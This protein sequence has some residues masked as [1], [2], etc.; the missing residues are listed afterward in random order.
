[1][2]FRMIPRM[3]PRMSPRLIRLFLAPLSALL[4]LCAA[5]ST[6]AQ[7]CLTT[8]SC[9]AVHSPG[10]CNSAACCL[11]VCTVDPTCCSGNWDA[12][13]VTT[14]NQ[15]CVGYCGAAISGSC[16]SSH[17][18]PACSNATCCN[19]VCATDPYCCATAWDV[20]CAQYASFLCPGTPGT[21][22]SAS[23]SCFAVHSTGACSDATCCNA[24][25]TIDPTCCSSAWVM[26]CVYAANETC[27]AGC[28]PVIESNAQVEVEE[29][30]FS[31]NDPCFTQ[32][33]GAPEEITLGRQ[34]FGRLGRAATFV[35]P[36]D[37][38]V[39][40]FSVTDTDGDGGA[41]VT[42]TF[43]SS[44]VAWAAIVSDAACAPL[45]SALRTVSSQLCVDTVSASVCLAPGNYRVVVAAGAYPT[46]GGADISCTSPNKY[47]L[48]I[49]AVQNCGSICSTAQ[50]SCFVV[51]DNPGCDN[52]NCC[53]SVCTTDPFCCNQLW[54]STCVSRAGTMCLSGP[55]ANDTCAN[56][57]AAIIGAQTFNTIRA[58]IEWP[59]I[60]K[61]C[62]TATFAR[63]VFFSWTAD[64]VGM[65]TVSTC[66]AWFDTVLAVYDGSCTQPLVVTCNDDAP[67]C[68]GVGA[69]KVT[70]EAECGTQYFFRV[71]QRSVS[72]GEATL[73]LSAGSKVCQSCPADFDGDGMVGASDLSLVLASWGLVTGDLDGD[74][75]TGASDLSLLLAAWGTCN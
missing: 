61:S 49:N 64:R 1:M 60:P 41:S 4:A 9:I 31:S 2:A 54:D 59:Q 28:S 42:M 56:A 23:G 48:T 13:C 14:A 70:F 35:D 15:V 22:G 24:V 36:I 47:T 32:S 43:A 65:I 66:G 55:P 34:V 26:F 73:T 7:F 33:G 3:I 5:P 69:S 63:D 74:A 62:S 29:C 71:G 51:R 53:T 45:A 11:S 21:C 39:Y 50:G 8:Q 37:V 19:N 58:N 67:L 18:N 38:D 20:N 68:A 57:Q 12:F 27:V 17:S 40:R 44:P 46:I 52:P 25:C 72:G 16:Y 6:Q 10:G 30:P 75:T